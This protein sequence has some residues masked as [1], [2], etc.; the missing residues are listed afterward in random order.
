LQG[1]AGDVNPGYDAPY[2]GIERAGELGRELADAVS[3]LLAKTGER[4]HPGTPVATW[5]SAELPLVGIPS[6][7]VLLETSRAPGLDGEWARALI[8]HPE[9]VRP[10]VECRL[11]LWSLGED[12]QLLG[13]SGEVTSDYGLR[14]RERSGG[15]TL[16]I[17][18]SN[19]MVGYLPTAR[20]IAA[21][22]YE[23]DVSARCYLLPGTFD[24]VIE[25]R[26]NDAVDSLLPTDGRP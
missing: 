15:T 3:A 16:P 22:G 26:L 4:L 1:C 21:G 5:A 2:A 11:Q 25:R 12:L 10:S 19:G 18:Y 13:M 9:L 17:A 6:A 8:A 7:D 14:I 23:V 20:Q 24:P